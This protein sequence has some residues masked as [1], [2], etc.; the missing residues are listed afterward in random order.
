MTLEYYIKISH[1]MLDD[2]RNHIFR[3]CALMLFIKCYPG[4]QRER[5]YNVPTMIATKQYIHDNE[6]T[7]MINLE[8]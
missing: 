5:F 6:I 7:L 2:Q 1:R 4:N 3:E 8:I